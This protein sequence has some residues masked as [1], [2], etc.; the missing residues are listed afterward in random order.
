MD[1]LGRSESRFFAWGRRFCLDPEEDGF[2]GAGGED[3]F[4]KECIIRRCRFGVRVSG[5]EFRKPT[6]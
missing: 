5:D 3:G 1:D 2:M 6:G 4:G